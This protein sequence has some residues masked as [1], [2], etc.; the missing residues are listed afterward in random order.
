MEFEYR[1]DIRDNAVLRDSFNALTRQVFDFDFADWHARGW[2]S[3]AR[4]GYT[5]HALVRDG[6]VISN[7]S[8]TPLSFVIAG[9]PMRALQLGTVM[10]APD[11]RGLGLQRRLM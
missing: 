9:E 1:T 3:A 11:F 2:W 7:V 8:A 5:P 4:T 10:T 6:E